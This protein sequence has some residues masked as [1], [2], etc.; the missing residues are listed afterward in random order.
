MS[1]S[2]PDSAK[3]AA[4]KQIQDCPEKKKKKKLV[5]LRQFIAF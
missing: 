1:F 4:G 5:T 3:P 2:R